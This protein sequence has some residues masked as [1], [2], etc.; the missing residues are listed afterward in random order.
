MSE[1]IDFD[2]ICQEFRGSFV[3]NNLKIFNLKLKIK[4]FIQK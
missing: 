3:I 2:K 4:I 1:Q